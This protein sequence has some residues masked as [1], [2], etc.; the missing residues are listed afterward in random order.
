MHILMIGCGY[1]G[2]RYARTMR[3]QGH[4]VTALTRSPERSISF[5]QE[6]IESVIGNVLDRRSLRAV[7]AADVCVYAVGFDRS[8]AEDKRDVYVDG[9]RNVLEQLHGHI[10]RFVYVSS[11]SV[12][13][14]QDGS[15]VNEDSAT[16]PT[17]E[18]GRICLEAEQLLRDDSI[19]GAAARTTTI[20]RLSGIYGPGRLIGRRQQLLSGQSLPGNPQAWL[21]LIHIDDIVHALVR[22]TTG[23]CPS[24]LYLLSDNQPNRRIDFYTALA[25]ELATPPPVMGDSSEG[26]LGK[27][28]DNSLIRSELKIELQFPTIVE[29][30]PS[31]VRS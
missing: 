4:R 20:L 12:Y 10:P 8:S 9:L 16:E 13:G 2:L 18:S 1:V 31:A 22:L 28:C 26:Q 11:T 24:P 19:K 6:G 7:P 5:Q 25:R 15:W 14:Q 27:R 29:G 23:P 3:G 21:N 30:L 17:T